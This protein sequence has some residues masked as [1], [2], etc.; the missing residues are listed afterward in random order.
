MDRFFSLSCLVLRCHIS[1]MQHSLAQGYHTC[2]QA[3]QWPGRFS[4]SGGISSRQLSTASGHL[5][6]KTQPLGG[7]MGLGTSP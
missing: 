5:G 1:A 2:E 7:F 6:W 3:T 4:S